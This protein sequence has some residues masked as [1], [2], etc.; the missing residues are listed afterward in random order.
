MKNSECQN[1]NRRQYEK[2]SYRKW[3][4]FLLWNITIAWYISNYWYQIMLIQGESMKPK[5]HNLQFVILDKHSNDYKRGDVVAF[6][7]EKLSSVLV[8]RIVAVP[9][10]SVIIKKGIL[11]ISGKICDYY[12][13]NY[14]E[15]A[16]L[17]ADT[18]YLHEDEYI[19]IGD[20]ISESKDSRYKEVGVIR[21]ENI[22]GEIINS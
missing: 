17:L 13:D 2:K 3:A 9:G 20:N 6:K 1:D 14:F 12:R 15:Y 22:I 11:Y 21:K 8:K 7:N 10:E 19:V 18:I 5:Y 4:F 16:G